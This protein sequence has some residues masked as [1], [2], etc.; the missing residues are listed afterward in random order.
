[1]GLG[2][3]HGHSPLPGDHRRVLGI[4]FTISVGVLLVQAV[5]TY[6][7]GSLA[8][9]TD[10]AHVLTDATGL[11]VALLAAHL[12]LRPASSRRT[13]GFR[14]VEV[15]AAFVQ[16]ALL[17]VV[18][19]YA[20]VEG[21]KRLSSPPEVPS[22]ELL[23]FGVVGLAGNLVAILVLTSARSANLNL[24]AAFLEA[25]NDA[26]GSVGVIAAA[27]VMDTTAWRQ[28]DAVAGLL[29]AALI[30]PRAFHLLRESSRVL[31]EFT[32]AGLDLD[33][34]RAHMLALDHVH[35]VHD[36]HASTVATGLPIIT[37][38]VV[39]DPTCFEDGHAP[40]ILD[41]LRSC[42]AEHFE[43]SIEHSTFQLETPQMADREAQTHS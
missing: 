28:A 25:M 41:T 24:R 43:V 34:V 4:A 27:I 42:V 39:V 21:L 3:D 30:V 19:V 7:T 10:T 36:L 40:Q 31:L 2:H 9:L 35:D 23:I 14:R 5:G 38:H 16:A 33:Q 12:V 15:V 18:G 8:L 1:M 6:L 32:P 37:A 13:W 29:I 20:V 22:T 11:G 26:L 17:L